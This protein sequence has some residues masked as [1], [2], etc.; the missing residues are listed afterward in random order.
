MRN[1]SVLKRCAA[2]AGIS[3]MPFLFSSDRR[4]PGVYHVW[5]RAR[6]G[7]WLFRDDED[8]QHFEHLINRHLSSVEHRDKRGR[9]VVCL[10]GLVRLCARNLLFS[11]FHLVLW[12]RQPGGIESL[13]KRVL[14][15]YA[16]YHHDKYGTSGQ[17]LE[18][19]YRARRITDRSSF[20]WRIAYVHFNRKSE[21]LD[22]RFSTHRWFAGDD[23]PPSWIEV[24]A[25]LERFGGR[26]EYLRYL[27][28]YRELRL[29]E[30]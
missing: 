10:R 4:L 20:C 15:A 7:Q 28:Q 5:G 11:H 2:I 9:I 6:K 13:M 23:D 30:P 25:T 16:R 14:V 29:P 3:G 21:G 27:E 18:G 24:D 26:A 19:N 8:R 17:L 22:W 12:Q 1:L